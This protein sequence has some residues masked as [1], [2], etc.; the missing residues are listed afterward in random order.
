MSFHNPPPVALF[1]IASVFCSP[2]ALGKDYF[3]TIGG[4]YGPAGNQASIESNVLFLQRTVDELYGSEAEYEIY[5]ADGSDPK[6]DVQY[7]DAELVERCPA[8]HRLMSIVLGSYD[9]IGLRYRDHRIG[10]V[11]GPTEPRP[12]RRR[13]I[14]FGRQLEAGDRLIVYVT[15][16]GGAADT[17]SD[18]GDYDYEYDEEGEKWVARSSASPE[19]NNSDQYNTSF[20]LWDREEVSAVKFDRWLDRIP[21]EIEVVLVMVQCYAGGFANSIFLRHDA[22]LGLTP[23]RRCGFF[24]QVHD[25]GAAGCTPE[26]NEADYQEFSSFFWAALG[27]KTRT[28]D[29]IEPPD[30]NHDGAVSFAEAHAYAVAESD[31]IDIPTT[32]SEAL[33]RTYSRL[34]R[35]GVDATQDSDQGIASSFLGLFGKQPEAADSAPQSSLL[36]ARGEVSRLTEL[37]RP[38]Q[39]AILQSLGEKL[40]LAQPAT[41]EAIRLLLTQV[42]GE[43]TAIQTRFYGASTRLQECETELKKDVCEVWPELSDGFSPMIAELTTER[44][45]EFVKTVEALPSYAA[46]QAAQGKAEGL[47]KEVLAARRKE[48]KVQRLLRTIENIVYAQNL[49]RCAPSDIV[50]RYEQLVQLESGTLAVIPDSQPVSGSRTLSDLS[51]D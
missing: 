35:E 1:L 15:G 22:E 40:K 19:D 13:L 14:R 10:N 12:L 42:Q 39:K 30:Y 11:Q 46:W 21:P 18:Y 26:A 37:A 32:T 27:G 41:V 38:E 36:V 23:H 6:P 33:L 9:A 7:I 20:Y 2:A 24:A 51:K 3:L 43:G 45:D 47:T 4:G 49:P 16:H 25:R 8:A 48:A 17:S 28:G 31:T 44:A 29:A 5:F 50:Q 34:G